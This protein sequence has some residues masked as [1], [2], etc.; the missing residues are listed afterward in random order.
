MSG[1]LRVI[2]SAMFILLVFCQSRPSSAGIYFWNA[3]DLYPAPWETLNTLLRNLVVP[4]LPEGYYNLNDH[5]QI[6]HFAP[7][8]HQPVFANKQRVRTVM[9]ITFLTNIRLQPEKKL[10]TVKQPILILTY[11]TGQQQLAT[12]ARWWDYPLILTETLTELG[13]ATGSQLEISHRRYPLTASS[14]ERLVTDFSI[15]TN[16]KATYPNYFYS[17][18]RER[19]FRRVIETIQQTSELRKKTENGISL[20]CLGCGRGIEVDYG[21]QQLTT[22]F[23]TPVAAIG[24]DINCALVEY[25]RAKYPQYQFLQ[26]CATEASAAIEFWTKKTFHT[27]HLIVVIALGL[28]AQEV[29]PGTY[30][31]LQILQQVA[32]PKAV[33]LMMVASYS[34]PLFN[35]HMCSASGWNME[36][37]VS[38][39]DFYVGNPDNMKVGNNLVIGNRIY[40]FTPMTVPQMTLHVARESEVRNQPETRAPALLDLSMSSHPTLLFSWLL[41]HGSLHSMDTVD[42]SWSACLPENEHRKLFELLRNWGINN[43][44]VSG[45]EP[46]YQESEQAIKEHYKFSIFKRT[47]ALYSEE[48]PSIPPTLASLFMPKLP[49]LITPEHQDR[50]RKLSLSQSQQE[51]SQQEKSQ[52]EKKVSF[53]PPEV[54]MQYLRHLISFLQAHT[55]E[56]VPT[57]HDGMCL[58]HALSHHSGLDAQSIQ[59]LI[60]VTTVEHYQHLNQQLSIP[61]NILD[62]VIDNIIDGSWELGNYAQISIA[63][64]TLQQDIVLIMP[65]HETGEL[66]YQHFPAGTSS[67]NSWQITNINE[68]LILIHDG[69]DHYVAGIVSELSPEQLSTHNAFELFGHSVNQIVPSSILNLIN[70]D[71]LTLSATLKPYTSQHTVAPLL[72]LALLAISGKG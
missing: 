36:T 69:S 8:D 46:W 24:L 23:N 1:I 7:P 43:I 12:P 44:I 11:E 14:T 34:L 9:V 3:S 16:A 18:M 60:M 37:H 27:P 39:A 70:K 21:Y 50:S 41:S 48:V 71:D 47:D 25:A 42:L 57:Q 58:Y 49:D 28:I 40:T 6:I 54:R 59:Q 72:W 17:T 5:I 26:T 19:L 66:Q 68:T 55:I 61:E 10:A 32:M 30:S 29:L 31:A 67:D 38:P 51:K 20:L 13:V 56:V 63:A 35:Q 52:Q 4:D 53:L 2:R 62:E 15:L 22:A 33:D 65:N 64:F 45:F